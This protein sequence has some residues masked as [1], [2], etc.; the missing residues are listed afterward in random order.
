MYSQRTCAV[1]GAF[2]LFGGWAS[3]IWVFLRALFLHLQICWEINP[4]KGFF[5]SALGAGFGIPAI[6]L[7]VA[8]GLT[9]VSYRFGSICHIN[10]KNGLQDFWGP[11]LAFAALAAVLQ[12][13]TLG[14]CVQVYVK[15]LLDDKATTDTSSSLPRYN[16]SI[17]TASA[18]R[19]YRRVKRVVQL[20]WRGATVVLLIIGE[21][22]FFAV[23]FV[24]MDNTTQIT[25]AFLEKASPWLLCLA[26][27]SAATLFENPTANKTKCLPLASGLVQPEGVVLAVLVILGLSGVW[28]FI[29][30]GRY[31]MALGWLDLIKRRL[32]PRHEFVSA[33]AQHHDP[34]TYE[35]LNGPGATTKS[36]VV[37]DLKSPDRA[38]LSPHSDHGLT[39]DFSPIDYDSKMGLNQHPP[40][41]SSRHNDDKTSK[42]PNVNIDYFGT[43]PTIR[44][45][46]YTS[47]QTSYST[48]RPPSA[49]ANTG[50][51]NSRGWDPRSTHAKGASGDSGGESSS[52][53]TDGHGGG[54]AGEARGVAIT[55]DFGR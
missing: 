43:I 35:M 16:T 40:Y 38:I 33:D 9:G 11:L 21:V 51:G 3:V 13:I 19:T 31:S 28:C 47:P 34:R 20:Q 10:H 50:W 30:F 41:P 18:R 14:Y 17:S 5:Y 53:S 52:S 55:K 44:T 4:S 39:S 6:G 36:G 48:P 15:S 7:G 49:Q 2:L 26:S 32:L 46:T 27:G 24:S 42:G 22:V 29:L 8:L 25:A 54:N 1:S 45:R 37:F 23:V 12:F